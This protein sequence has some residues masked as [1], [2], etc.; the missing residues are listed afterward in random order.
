MNRGGGA[1]QA[2]SA[3]QKRIG[4]LSGN[5]ELEKE[6]SFVRNCRS[7]CFVDFST[8]FSCGFEISKKVINGCWGDVDTNE[9]S[10]GENG[11]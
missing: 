9:D 5:L 3:T 7:F 11:A 6:L 2:F 1:W 8:S 4:I 10:G